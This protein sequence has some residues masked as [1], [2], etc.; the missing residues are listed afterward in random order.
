MNRPAD[1]NDMFDRRLYKEMDLLRLGLESIKM[2]LSNLED[3]IEE[4]SA[5]IEIKQRNLKIDYQKAK[6]EVSTDDQDLDMYFSDETWRHHELFPAFTYNSILVSLFSFFETRLKLICEINSRKQFSNVKPSHLSGSDVERY[7]RYL[8]VVAGINLDNLHDK[9]K[10]ITDIQKLRNA[11]IHNSAHIDIANDKN[12]VQFIKGDN[13]IKFNEQQG[14]F[15]I[16]DVTFLKDFSKLLLSFFTSVVDELV[17]HKAVARNATMPFD[18][19]DWGIEKTETLLRDI[20][21]GLELLKEN[22][23]RTDEFKDLDLKANIKGLFGSMA[24]NLTKLYSFFCSAEWDTKDRDLIVNK[25]I[26]GLEHIKKVY[27]HQS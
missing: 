3:Y 21:H 6:K 4:T 18:N 16:N 23:N 5:T 19:T 17:K 20:V 1:F 7:K 11:I 15:Y 27:K 13:R 12:M 9:W 26:E 2:E 14:S 10:R 8:T 25:G 24:Y 22:E